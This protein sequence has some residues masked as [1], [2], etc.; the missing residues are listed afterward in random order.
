MWLS[1]KN[2]K[3][4][5]FCLDPHKLN[6]AVKCEHQQMPTTDDVISQLGGKK[7]FS[8]F[9]QKDSFW[10]VVLDS[11]SALKCTFNNPC[12]RYCFNRMLFGLC[13]AS[14]VLQ[15]RNECRLE[16]LKVYTLSLMI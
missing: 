15:N 16:I 8:I 11:D 13:S 7:V 12:R 5:R 10:Q 4:L 2:N 3:S 1:S 9:D 6:T 14:E